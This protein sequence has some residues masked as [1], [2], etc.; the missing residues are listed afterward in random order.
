[1]VFLSFYNNFFP[2]LIT[3]I[4]ELTT[5]WLIFFVCSKR[6]VRRIRQ[7]NKNSLPLIIFCRN[8]YKFF[9]II[10]INHNLLLTSRYICRTF[11]TFG[12]HL[13]GTYLSVKWKT[14]SQKFIPLCH[15]SYFMLTIRDEHIDN[16][17][18]IKDEHIDNEWQIYPSMSHKLFLLMVRDER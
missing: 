7:S 6:K 3:F 4:Q 9:K 12:F 2:M 1:M 11:Y 5:K 16:E 15:I 14:K 17:W 13:W 8:H 18:Q 10:I